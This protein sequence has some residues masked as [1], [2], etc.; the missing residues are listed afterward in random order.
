MT[1]YEYQIDPT[2]SGVNDSF[3]FYSLVDVEEY[4]VAII[5][6]NSRGTQKIKMLQENVDFKIKKTKFKNMVDI[7]VLTPFKKEGILRIKGV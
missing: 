2:K 5:T 6:K 4:F 3:P 7:I 1:T